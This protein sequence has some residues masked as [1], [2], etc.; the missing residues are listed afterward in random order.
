MKSIFNT[1]PSRTLSIILSVALLTT[2]FSSCSKKDDYQYDPNV[3]SI[4]VTNAASASLPQD[5]YFG[6]AKLNATPLAY[7][8]TVGYVN[9]TGSPTISFKNTGTADVNASSTTSLSPGK[10]YMVYYTDAKD[11]AVFVNERTAPQSGKARI[12]FIN[13]TTAVGS[14]VDFG[15]SGGGK[16]VSG[17]TYKAASS[18]QDV[19][20]TKGYSLYTGGSTSVLLDIPITLQAGGIYSL[21]ITGTTSATV[22]FKIIGEN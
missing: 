12:R 2:I 8:Q 11:I 16:I 4:A 1:K 17:L 6:N 20:P 5:V 9:I 13:L 21:Y 7:S 18:Y 14:A 10:Y 3:L 22:G 15:I 19:D